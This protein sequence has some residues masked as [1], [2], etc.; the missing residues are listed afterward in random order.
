MHYVGDKLTKTT[1]TVYYTPEGIATEEDDF[2]DFDLSDEPE[3]VKEI[4][5]N[6]TK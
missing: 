4:S 3:D 1:M 6:S 2:D 5:N